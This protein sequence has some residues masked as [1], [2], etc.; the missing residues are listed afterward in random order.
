MRTRPISPCEPIRDGG[1]GSVPCTAPR[2][3]PGFVT[4]PTFALR[5]MLDR[6]THELLTACQRCQLILTRSVSEGTG[7]ETSLTL[8][9]KMFAIAA[10]MYATHG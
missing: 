3:R 8:R 9:V 6:F 2:S 7:R 1:L 5:R 4:E 10:A